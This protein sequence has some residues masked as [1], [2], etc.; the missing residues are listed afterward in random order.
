MAISATKAIAAIEDSGGFVTQIAKRLDC[1]RKTVYNLIDK[2]PTVKEALEDER[3]KL[4]DMT[5]GKLLAQIK[6]GNMTAIIFYL[7]TQAKDRGYIERQ[8]IT[9]LGEKLTG[10]QIYLPAVEEDGE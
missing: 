6:T 8:D 7:K 3:E 4:K 9:S 10:P 5:E 2:Y 1:T